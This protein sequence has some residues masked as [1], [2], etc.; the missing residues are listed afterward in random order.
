[1]IS[2][3]L[4]EFKV[5]RRSFHAVSLRGDSDSCFLKREN[6]IQRLSNVGLVKLEVEGGC[7]NHGMERLHDTISSWSDGWPRGTKKFYTC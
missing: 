7:M 4:G 5:Q 3:L 1:M 2:A 6:K